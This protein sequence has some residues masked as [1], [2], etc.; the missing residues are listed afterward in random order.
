MAQPPYPPAPPPGP[1]PGYPPQ[2]Y[3][4]APQAGPPYYAPPPRSGLP[5]WLIAV[6]VVLGAIVVF[7]GILGVLAIYGV[8]K[9]I[10]NAKTAEARNS[11]G[12]IAKEA[13]AAFERDRR[14][15][16]SASRTVPVSVVNV[17]GKKYLSSAADWQVDAGRH[18]GF[19][20]LGF[21]L[22]MPQYYMYS[23]KA[24]G[25]NQPG[26]GF[27]ASAVGDLN[28]DGKTSLFKISG[29]VS[30]AGTL[31]IEPNLLEQDPEE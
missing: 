12:M 19:A 28:G 2:G 13:E 30:P 7:G 5:G 26:D 3:Y 17:S 31:T 11:V 9:Y 15:C 10:A 27:E 8:R 29:T 21:S 22:A 23:Y 16:P 1:P 20:C 6:F 24:H 18:A 25:T 14:L 4:G